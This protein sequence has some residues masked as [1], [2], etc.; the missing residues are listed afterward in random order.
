M[1]LISHD[2][3]CR[4]ITASTSS[5][6]SDLIQT[7]R[8]PWSRASEIAKQLSHYPDSELSERDRA[9]PR[10]AEEV[11]T[12][13]TRRRPRRGG[14]GPCDHRD[15]V[16]TV[17]VS[18]SSGTLRPDPYHRPTSLNRHDFR[19]NMIDQ[20]VDVN[21]GLIELKPTSHHRRLLKSEQIERDLATTSPIWI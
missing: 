21:S 18:F 16:S 11:A 7:L 5:R 14:G 12:T 15:T 6:A 4:K 2:D 13:G 8:Y 17:F 3:R 19:P 20:I 1:L 9:R 10:W